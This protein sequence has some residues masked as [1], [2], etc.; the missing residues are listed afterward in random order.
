MTTLT[1]GILTGGG[2]CPGLNPTI[3]GIVHGLIDRNQDGKTLCLGIKDGW[4][5]LI[6]YSEKQGIA[7][8]EHSFRNNYDVRI[9][10]KVDVSGW[11]SMGGTQLGS[12]RT[13]PFKEIANSR[14]GFQVA[15]MYQKGWY[16]FVWIEE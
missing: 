4:R 9:L 8:T 14:Q 10:T 6:N 13:N 2:D 7:T 11:D 16:K 3:R 12:S 15:Y 5:G 1:V